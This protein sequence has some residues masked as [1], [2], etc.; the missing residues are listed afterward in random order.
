[1][2]APAL[3]PK[4]KI[5]SDDFVERIIVE[6]FSILEKV[7]IYIENP[8]AY[9]HLQACGASAAGLEDKEKGIGRLTFPRKMVE[10]ALNTAPSAIQLWNIIGDKCCD[11]SGDMVNFD[12]GSAALY[13]YD[14]KQQK[15]RKPVTADL[16]DFVH[17]VDSLPNFNLQSTALVSSDV[18]EACGDSY[19]LYLALREGSKPVITGTFEKASFTVMKEMLT[20]VRGGA[21]ELKAKP[22]AIFDACPS[23]PLMWSDLTTQSVMEAALAGIPSEFVSMPLTGSTAPM[24]LSGAVTQH[25]AET[26]C[27]IVIAQS[28]AAGAPVIWG[29]SPSAMDMRFGTTPMGAIETMMIDMADVAVGKALGLPTHAYMGL[30]DAKRVDY[31][32]GLESAMGI[33][34]AALSGVNMVSGPGMMDFESCQSFEKLVLDNEIC[35]MAYRLIEGMAQRDSVMALDL[36]TALEPG[37]HLLTHPH[38]LKWFRDEIYSPGKSIDRRARGSQEFTELPTAED[39]AAAEVEKILAQDHQPAL[40]EDLQKELDNVMEAELKRAG[41]S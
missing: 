8:D 7:G 35:G 3:R 4:V 36:L 37:G 16:I 39:R 25:A 11:L 21:A 14:R 38:T 26:L 18:L 19:R 40:N 30:S 27:G 2:I 22:L 23:P 12:P 32:A 13:L 41:G 20:L 29:G 9:Q 5:I 24:S 33:L 10:D 34:L 6:A 1:M 17:L 15:I 31:Q 28:A